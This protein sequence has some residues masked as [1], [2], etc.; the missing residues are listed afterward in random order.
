VFLKIQPL[1]YSL[2]FLAGLELIL[3]EEGLVLVVSSF[4]FLISLY[5]G[6][7]LGGKWFFSILPVFF[8]LSSVALLY[9]VTLRYEQQIFAA[10][11]SLMYYLS[12]YG[13]M[14]LGKYENDQTARGM[15]MAAMAATVFFA[16]A[17]AYGLYL[18]FL[19]PLYWLMLAYL[20]VTLLVSYQYFSLIKKETRTVW[21]Y[22]FILA[23][24]MAELIWTMNF[25]PFGYLTTGVIALILY[26]VLWDIVQSHF[27]N[28]LSRKR[29]ISNVFLFSFLIILILVTSKWIPVI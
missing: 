27:L 14:R 8:T 7:K 25:W 2:V 3:F 29:A 16:Y 19:V 13:A 12:L 6:R 4:L 24:I 23:L 9:L 26:Y 17:G 15:N 1:L 11:A 22:S 28:A 20:A 10:I 21:T 18:N 5:G